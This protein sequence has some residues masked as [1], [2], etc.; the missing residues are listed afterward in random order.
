MNYKAQ[1]IFTRPNDVV[2]Y[3]VGDVVGT[4]MQLAPFPNGILGRIVAASMRIDVAALPVGLGAHRLHLYNAPPPSNLA[5]NAV[6][7]LVAGDRSAYEG[8]VDFVVPGDV[9]STLFVKA[10]GLSEVVQTVGGLWAYLVTNAAYTP[11][12]LQAFVAQLY[13]QDV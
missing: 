3:G 4:R 13:A 9:G 5:D 10:S 7:D 6:W 12:A 11:V 1:A 2:P 8:F